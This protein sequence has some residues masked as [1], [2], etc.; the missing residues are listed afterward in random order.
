MKSLVLVTLCLSIIGLVRCSGDDNVQVENPDAT[1]LLVRES[2]QRGVE[3][4]LIDVSNDQA[5]PED[6]E[7]YV[8][9]NDSNIHWVPAE[10]FADQAGF[11][12]QEKGQAPSV[13]YS[14][15]EMGGGYY[16]HYRGGRRGGYYRGQTYHRR[17]VRHGYYSHYRPQP[18]YRYRPY[19]PQYVW[20]N[21]WRVNYTNFNV[22][23]VNP[24]TPGTVWV[25]GFCRVPVTYY[26]WY[27]WAP[28]W[29]W[30]YTPVTWNSGC[31]VRV[32]L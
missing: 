28:A 15:Q 12:W 32:F 25:G 2:A 7:S 20:N 13:N 17:W 29:G 19:R 18:Y 6:F 10:D 23:V 4:A 5:K 9:D 11:D 30:F 26:N 8:R 3:M 21:N 24:C 27:T 31:R 1:A 16:G 22:N 14:A